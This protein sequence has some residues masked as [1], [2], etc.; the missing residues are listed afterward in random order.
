M[1]TSNKILTIAFFAIIVACNNL[2]ENCKLYF[3]FDH[4]EHYFLDIPEDEVVK[5][6]QKTN[7]TEMESRQL[8]LLTDYFPETLADTIHLKDLEKM[9]FVKTDLSTDKFEA[10]NTIF[11]ERHHQYPVV[12]ACMAIY[13]DLLVFKKGNKTIGIAKICFDCGKHVITGTALNTKD[14]GQSG[15]YDKLYDIL[16]KR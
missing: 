9:S 4:V 10:L 11:C 16:H 1:T 12:S 15:D 13:R 6:A 5:T 7:K 3:Q 2:T 8:Q 14:F